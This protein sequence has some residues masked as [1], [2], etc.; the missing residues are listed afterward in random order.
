MNKKEK[1]VMGRMVSVEF[2]KLARKVLSGK[3]AELPIP[4]NKIKEK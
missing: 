1:N 2:M 4:E 3:K